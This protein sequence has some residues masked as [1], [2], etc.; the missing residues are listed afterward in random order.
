MSDPKVENLLDQLREQGQRLTVARRALAEAL[1]LAAGH[2]SADELAVRVQ[3]SHPG[4]H[5]A[6]VYRVLE[7]FERL[8]L[9]EHVHLGHGRAVYHLAHEAHQHLV[10]ED[11]GSVLEAPASLFEGVERSIRASEGFVMRSRHFAVVGRC[12]QCSDPASPSGRDDDR[13]DAA[14]GGGATGGS[15]AATGAAPRRR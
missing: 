14:A 9:V 7:A 15:E 12:R 2:L 3:R 13:G 6:T 4:V 8:G 5:R 11:C 1:V 10:C